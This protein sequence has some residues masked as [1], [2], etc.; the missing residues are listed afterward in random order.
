ME[1]L[2]RFGLE[3]PKE[4]FSPKIINNIKRKLSV[5]KNNETNTE[6]FFET[7]KK[8]YIPSYTFN[9]EQN[10]PFTIVNAKFNRQN[11]KEK[12]RNIKMNFYPKNVVQINALNYLKF[13]KENILA[14]S[15]GK[16]K[17]YCAIFHII[18]NSLIPFIILHDENTIQQWKKA[19]LKFSNINEKDIFIIKG[20][21]SIKKIKDEFIFLASNKTIRNLLI[22]DKK[23]T[24]ELIQ[25]LSIDIK[26]FDEAHLFLES[27]NFINIF[28]PT[29]ENLF[30]TA[31]I[32]RSLLKEEEILNYMLPTHNIYEN[33]EYDIT[34][35]VF[36]V[37]YNTKPEERNKR[38][39]Q[40]FSFIGRFDVMK[41]FN[42][43]IYK[44]EGSLEKLDYYLQL[45][46]DLVNKLQKKE[47][48]KM[49]IVMK[50]VVTLDLV[51]KMLED[52]N[53]KVIR[54]YGSDR[55]NTEDFP[56]DF[57]ILV[58]TDKLLTVAFDYPA[59]QTLIN[60]VPIKSWHTVKQ[61]AGRVARES[62]ETG[63][64]WARYIFLSDEGFPRFSESADA[65]EII[66]EER[67]NIRVKTINYKSLE[68]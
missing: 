1:I 63:K 55:I 13:E 49:A 11:N 33:L 22:E 53:F 9:K 26:V 56:D 41:Y 19:F 67:L 54:F 47:K 37:N 44:E 21:A 27:N 46:Y 66:F 52:N 45:I 18:T 34:P 5:K 48:H 50:T 20:K 43:Y 31:T 8:I 65:Q 58:A 28:L 25:R 42:K 40:N 6:Y 2:R 39:I 35:E 61:T 32:G 68:K 57:D 60:T 14:L 59:L 7:E 30:L 10:L 29:P 12:F 62:E 23:A 16:G 38:Y 15:P 24:F 36:R 64:T 17:T 4:D 3:I 51:A